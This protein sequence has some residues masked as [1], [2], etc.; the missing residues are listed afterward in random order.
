MQ[1]IMSQGLAQDVKKSLMRYPG[2]SRIA[3]TIIVGS[4]TRSQLDRSR[5]MVYSQTPMSTVHP[6]EGSSLL[7][8]S[9][10]Y[11]VGLVDGEGSFT[12]R[13]NSHLGRRNRME[14]RFYLKLRAEDKDLLDALARFFGCGTVYIQRDSR[15][16]H[17]LCYRYEVGNRKDLLEKILPFFMKFP[18]KSTSKRRDFEAFCKAMTIVC[19]GAHFTEEGIK[20]LSALKQTMH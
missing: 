9:P 3:M 11:V 13:L 19:A 14:P 6:H 8:L 18:P 5:E 7:Q 1:K 17:S 16:R 15:P 10:D 4:N 2:R 12:F 20:K